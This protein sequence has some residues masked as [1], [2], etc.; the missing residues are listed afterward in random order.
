MIIASHVL[1]NRFRASNSLELA[2]ELSCTP[3]VTSIPAILGEVQNMVHVQTPHSVTVYASPM[4]C[5]AHSQL[6]YRLQQLCEVALWGASD[7]SCCS[8]HTYLMC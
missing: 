6:L 1:A 3:D 8:Q 4:A 7:Q 5:E 2:T